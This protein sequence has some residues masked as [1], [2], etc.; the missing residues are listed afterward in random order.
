[1]TRTFPERNFLCLLWAK[2]HTFSDQI[3]VVS[4]Q[5]QTGLTCMVGGQGA[6]S[7]ILDMTPSDYW[8]QQYQWEINETQVLFSECHSI[9]KV[10]IDYA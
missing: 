8:T 10:P 5:I 9:Q 1:M 2:G 4:I 3:F 7:S 6:P